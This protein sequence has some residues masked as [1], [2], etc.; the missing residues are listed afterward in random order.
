[1]TINHTDIKIGTVINAKIGN[2]T[3]NS[4]IVSDLGINNDWPIT[5]DQG[6]F[7]YSEITEIVSQPIEEHPVEATKTGYK[8]NIYAKNTDGS[9]ALESYIK[10][11]LTDASKGV[12]TLL[13]LLDNTALHSVEIYK[14]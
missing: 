14:E 5:T 2:E 8:A 3:Y 7:K 13:K 1:M 11:D 4:A 9:K 6:C 12:D 10:V